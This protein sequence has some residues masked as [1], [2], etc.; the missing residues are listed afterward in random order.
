MQMHIV[1]KQFKRTH[2]HS[3]DSSRCTIN[4]RNEHH[5]NDASEWIFWMDHPEALPN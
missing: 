4:F 1:K 5:P 2:L 3:N